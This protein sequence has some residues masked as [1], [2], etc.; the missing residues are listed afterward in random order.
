MYEAHTGYADDGTRLHLVDAPVQTPHGVV[1]ICHGL[2]EH[3][4]RYDHVIAALNQAGW[5][6]YG[7]DLR[8]HGRSAGRRGHVREFADYVN[9]VEALWAHVQTVEPPTLPRV[10]LGHSMGGLVAVHYALRHSEL[11]GLALSGPLLGVA[12][13][14]PAWKAAAGRLLSSLWPTLAMANEVD[15]HALSRDAA[16]VAA[17][18]ADPLVHDRVTARWFTSMTAAMATAQTRAT[19]INMPLWLRHGAADT[20]TDPAAA[21]AFAE[22]VHASADTQLVPNARHEIFNEPERETVL[23]DLRTWLSRLPRPG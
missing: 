9:D 5:S 16:V 8:G 15:P 4:G 21:T 17:Y 19:A 1:A 18:E 2:G 14:V 20:V 22:R 6:V 7:L 11:A 12:A 23:N 3:I 10:Q 13:K